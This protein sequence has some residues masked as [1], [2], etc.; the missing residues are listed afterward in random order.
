MPI[1]YVGICL[2]Y[3]LVYDLA[4]VFG[5]YKLM[6]LLYVHPCMD[7]NT[8]TSRVIKLHYVVWVLYYYDIMWLCYHDV[9]MSYEFVLSKTF[10]VNTITSCVI[11]L[12]YAVCCHFTMIS[13]GYVIM[14]L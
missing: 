1:Y 3:V 5:I 7:V 4:Y 10:I 14:M 13:C 9:M 6:M 12:H 8:V 2:I 11:K